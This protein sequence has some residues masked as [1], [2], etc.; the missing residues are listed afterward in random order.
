MS[1][2]K[3]CVIGHPLGHTLS[4][5]IHNHWIEK[6]GLAARYEARP[7][8]PEM[9]ESSFY[10][11]LGEGFTGFNVTL[12]YKQ[13]IMQLCDELDDTARRIGA[14]NTIAV[15][16]KGKLRGQNTD[17]FGFIESVRHDA[18][19]FDFTARP[20]LVLGAG[21]AARA[22]VY[23][24]MRVGVPDIF[25]A[26]RTPENTVAL[27]RDFGARAVAWED[28]SSRNEEMGLV[29]NTTALGMTGQPP[30]IFDL[31]GLDQDSLV[32][33]IVYNPLQ[34]GLLREAAAR[35]I[36][37]VGGLGMLVH[38]ARAAFAAW[39]GIMPDYDVE[40]KEKLEAAL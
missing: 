12:P 4:P 1:V 29:V 15:G 37:T 38:Q 10:D 8:P 25:I 14:V 21:G 13:V 6:H 5:L 34:T 32:C 2:K 31:D 17:A 40:L 22:V 24:L 7:I 39:F 26:N 18:P 16:E 19:G 30:L 35:G 27:G 11:L 3:L 20:A 36:K 33:D 9:F 23:A 28:R